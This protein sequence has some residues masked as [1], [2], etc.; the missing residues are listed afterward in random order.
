MSKKTTDSE[1][2]EEGFWT[3]LKDYVLVAGREVVEKALFLFYAAQRQD[4]PVWAK[5]VIFGALAYFVSLLDAI[6]DFTPVVGYSDDL[7]A[8]VVALGLVAAYINDEV[9]EKA[10]KKMSDWFGTT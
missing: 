2:S 10:R 3:K 8:I 5:T 6:P 1:F 9:K 4:T 7:G